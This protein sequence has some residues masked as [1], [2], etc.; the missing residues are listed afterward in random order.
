MADQA[1]VSRLE[2]LRRYYGLMS[3]LADRQNGPRSIADAVSALRNQSGVYFFF[4]PGEVRSDSGG[5]QR[6]VRVGTHALKSGASSTLRGR[7]RQHGGTKG[8][9]GNHRGSIYRLLT[10]DAL[11]RCGMEPSCP[12]WGTKPGAKGEEVAVEQAVSRRLA[13]ASVVWLRIDDEPCPESERGWIE[14]NTIALLSNQAKAPL[15]PPSPS[16]LGHHSSRTRVRASGLW[17]QNHVDEAYDPVFLDDLERLIG[18]H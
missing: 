6:V 5:G 14:R 13:T 12:T 7:L 9:T 2:H 1:A 18:E 17:N 15:D 11:M 16:W 10:G 8:G 3:A 4:E